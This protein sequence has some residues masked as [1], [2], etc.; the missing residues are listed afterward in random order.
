MRVEILEVTTIYPQ[1]F[2]IKEGSFDL[3]TLSADIVCKMHID[4]AEKMKVALN[5]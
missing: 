1:V 5:N 3:K 2:V 4:D